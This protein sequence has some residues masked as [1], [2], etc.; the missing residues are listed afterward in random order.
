MH[1]LDNFISNPEARQDW[2]QIEEFLRQERRAEKLESLI[3]S[4][5]RV[6]DAEVQDEYLR[7]NRTA[8]VQWVGLRYADVPDSEVNLIGPRPSALLRSEP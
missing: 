1:L 2:I 5:V 4:A 8:T 3:T 7:R 6:S